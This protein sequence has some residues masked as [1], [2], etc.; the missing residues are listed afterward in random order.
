[1]FS[2]P[3][4]FLQKLHFLIELTLYILLSARYDFHR[5]V[6]LTIDVIV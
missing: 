1:M 6:F 2:V 3:R 5:Q 4:Y